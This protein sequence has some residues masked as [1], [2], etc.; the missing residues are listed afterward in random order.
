MK[1]MTATRWRALLALQNPRSISR[2]ARSLTLPPAHQHWLSAQDPAS[3]PPREQ[4]LDGDVPVQPPHAFTCPPVPFLFPR[5]RCL[6]L[7]HAV[8]RCP[9]LEVAPAC[10]PFLC[11]SPT[12]PPR[13]V[14]TSTQTFG[15]TALWLA[16]LFSAR[17]SRK[18][19]QGEAV[20]AVSNSCFPISSPSP[21]ILF[22]YRKFKH[23]LK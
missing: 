7:S 11:A 14:P 4:A 17:K 20:C 5:A 23:V 15:D 19:L 8:P 2:A 22:Y 3:G 18:F 6:T 13:T 16:P 21:F 10:L 12:L 1:V 9:M